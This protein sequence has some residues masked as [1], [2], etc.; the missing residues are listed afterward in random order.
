MTT[1]LEIN[2]GSGI[3]QFGLAVV[4][5]TA[6]RPKE[7]ELV[8]L[9]AQGDLPAARGAVARAEGLGIVLDPDVIALSTG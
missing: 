8:A 4:L 3:A 6:R 7:A 5:E 1:A 2:P 9:A